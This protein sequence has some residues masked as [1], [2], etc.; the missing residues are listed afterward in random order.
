MAR[1]YYK[2]E[3]LHAVL[4]GRDF[5]DFPS[6]NRGTH[7]QRW[8]NK[9]CAHHGEDQ[10]DRKGEGGRDGAGGN[11]HGTSTTGVSCRRRLLQLW[12]SVLVQ[13]HVVRLPFG[14][15]QL[16]FLS[17]SGS[18]VAGGAGPALELGAVHRLPDGDPTTSP[19]RH[20]ISCD[21]TPD[22]EAARVLGGRQ[23]CNPCRRHP[24]V[25]RGIPN[26]RPEGGD[27]GAP[28][29]DLPQPGAL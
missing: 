25:V 19:P 22:G 28:G 5:S 9:T 24:Q 4:H 3:S 11:H 10:G 1:R 23:A 13:H 8:Q 15:P 6:S 16:R 27:G 2:H 17:V 7:R 14:G 26:R 20:R 29:S 18:R 21:Q 12:A